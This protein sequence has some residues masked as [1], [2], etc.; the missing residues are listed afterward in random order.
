MDRSLGIVI[1][2]YEPDIDLLRSYIHTLDTGLKPAEIR[3]ELDGAS[4]EEV[5]SL[6]DLPVSIHTV[7][8]RRGKGAAITHGFDALRTDILAF[9]DADGS[10]PANSLRQIAKAVTPGVTDLVVGSRRHPDATIHGHQTR[11]RRWLGHV[12]AIVARH[13]LSVK[14]YDYQCG[15]KAISR[16]AWESVRQ[17]LF[18]SG[19]AW[20][21]EL[22]AMT[23]AL[24]HAVKEMP[25][26]WE[27]RPG[28]TV[29][30]VSTSFA[31]A[32]TLIDTYHRTKVL[33]NHPVHARIDPYWSAQ[34][35][36]IDRPFGDR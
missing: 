13:L 21:V 22:I 15:A 26:E 4:P 23:A 31:L 2:A 25:I 24:G 29:P 36:L 5:Q 33:E 6:S 30:P 7:S 28:S 1:P 20:D 32:R 14:L 16:D 3:L 35:P 8:N 12:F 27:D 9:T 17:H 11:V 34:P 10:T 19:F 18:A